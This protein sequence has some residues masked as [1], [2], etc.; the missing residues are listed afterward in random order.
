MR[1]LS[2]SHGSPLAQIRFFLNE[3]HFVLAYPLYY[4]I[5]E[6]TC[7]LKNEDSNSLISEAAKVAYLIEF[8]HR[9]ALNF[10]EKA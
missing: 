8:K 9:E 5:K 4:N 3:I 2:R 6:S 1:T 10:I 7:F